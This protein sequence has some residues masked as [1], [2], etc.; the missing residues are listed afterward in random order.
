MSVEGVH[1]IEE[2]LRCGLRVS[3]IFV[4]TG[5]ERLLQQLVD[6]DAA[7]SR[8]ASAAKPA[9]SAKRVWSEASLQGSM[10]E[11][12][13]FVELP[14]EVFDSA[15]TTE[16]PQGIAALLEPPLFALEDI[17]SEGSPASGASGA[18]SLIVV[19]AGLQDPG[20]LGTLIR[21]AEAFG[22]QG[23]IALPGTVSHW[24]PKAMRASS[25]S[26]FRL[27]VVA[28]EE[29]AAFAALRARG[30]QL[31]AATV[32]GGEAASTF[33]LT[34]PVALM[35]G[36]EGSGLPHALTAAAEASITIPFPGRVESLNAAVAASVL[37]YEAARQRS[38]Y[39][40]QRLQARGR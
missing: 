19:A 15:V 38:I 10:A 34:G 9:S 16:T 25:G 27:P 1:L 35:I 29:R 14:A 28:A 24:N 3:T 2:A 21:S 33:D 4:R 18:A 5:S 13:D 22:A 7:C 20:N 30:V 6:Q 26:V 12:V 39:A 8:A 17:L 31:L 40:E 11:T 36:N 37:L 32:A 23:L